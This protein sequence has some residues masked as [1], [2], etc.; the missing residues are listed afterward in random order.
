MGR[1]DN[2][3]N[4]SPTPI[5]AHGWNSMSPSPAPST[6]RESPILIGRWSYPFREGHPRPTGGVGGYRDGPWM[7]VADGEPGKFY[8]PGYSG[9]GSVQYRVGLQFKLV[10]AGRKDLINSF[11][12]SILTPEKRS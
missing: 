3:I 1:M 5:L 4:F 2:H 8:G 7:A 9:L 10:D 6:E 11:L 12:G